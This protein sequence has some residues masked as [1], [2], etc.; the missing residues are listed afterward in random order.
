[1]VDLEARARSRGDFVATL[2]KPTVL[3]P[4]HIEAGIEIE[5]PATAVELGAQPLVL[6]GDQVDAVALDRLPPPDIAHRAASGPLLLL[7]LDRHVAQAR[8]RF[9]GGRDIGQIGR[10][11]GG[12]RE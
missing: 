11:A 2:A 5:R 6:A 3:V 10:P 9:G 12:D 1:M 8:P 4:L 7:P